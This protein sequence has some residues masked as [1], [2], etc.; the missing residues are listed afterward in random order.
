MEV[1]IHYEGSG[2]TDYINTKTED[3]LLIWR[4]WGEDF[5]NGARIH[6]V[7]AGAWENLPDE[8]LHELAN[9]LEE[10]HLRDG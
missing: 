5:Q 7:A 2:L 4:E 6:I 3:T 8:F 1:L 9:R 10:D